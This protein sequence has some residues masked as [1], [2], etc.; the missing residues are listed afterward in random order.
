MLK[1]LTK[2]PDQIDISDIEELITSG[3]PE[4]QHLE[5]KSTLPSNGKKPD[6]WFDGQNKIGDKAR[7]ELLEEAVAFANAQ[8]GTLL[9]GISESKDK[10]PI[11]DKVMPLPE[12]AELADRLGKML[13]D[14]VK[15]QIPQLEVFGVPVVGDSG[16]IVIRV[17][18][19]RLAP[20][21]VA[22]TRI[23]SVRQADRC[24][25]M[26]MKD[27]QEMTL[28][29]HAGVSKDIERFEKRLSDRSAVFQEE[30]S[31]LI[32]PHESFGIRFTALPLGD[33]IQ[34][35]SVFQKS[36]HFTK[37]CPVYEKTDGPLR[38][39]KNPYGYPPQDPQSWRPMMRGT[40]NET[41]T[42]SGG[43]FMFSYQELHCDGLLELVYLSC[44]QGFLTNK[45]PHIPMYCDPDWPFSLFAN[46]VNWANHL[47]ESSSALMSEYRLQVEIQYK[48]TIPV[49]VAQDD[50]VFRQLQM[51]LNPPKLPSS[52][53]F[54]TYT[55]DIQTSPAVLLQTFYRDFW[56]WLGRHGE[57][58]FEIGE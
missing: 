51:L 31:R 4:G 30:L 1:I 40:R 46:T 56:N 49:Y 28:R 14:C 11:A 37:W 52:K 25:R 27:I 48:G 50:H 39:L 29:V 38:Q 53:I 24:E 22:T 44:N 16:V 34:F 18:Q 6:P 9:V 57:T 36:E 8:G 45:N 10:P 35:D 23:C 3:V 15:P 21:Q 19:S 58:E 41:E 54:P 5:F 7:N 12:C 32:T 47:R 43:S 42:Q 17:G 55:L 26:E 33:D 20:H 13:R 2:R